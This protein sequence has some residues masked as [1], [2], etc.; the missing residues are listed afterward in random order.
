MFCIDLDGPLLSD[1]YLS[2]NDYLDMKTTER[3]AQRIAFEGNGE[4][5]VRSK[6]FSRL[7]GDSI[8]FHCPSNGTSPVR[9]EF[10]SWNYYLT[11]TLPLWFK[12]DT[13]ITSAS[14]SHAGMYTCRT[15]ANI[16]QRIILTILRKSNKS[17]SSSRETARSP[18]LKIL[19]SH[20]IM[21]TNVPCRPIDTPSI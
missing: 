5:S 20:L 9:W 3:D 7:P 12:A 1:P 19:P 21:P 14:I 18:R 2:Q 10:L 8:H 11:R 17:R 15:D 4:E 6:S 16:H 13:R